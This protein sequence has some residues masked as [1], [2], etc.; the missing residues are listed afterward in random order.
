VSADRER[1][2]RLDPETGRP[3]GRQPLVGAGV[4]DIDARD[5]T[6]W[7]ANRR[8][9][10]VVRLDAS[11]GARLGTL[12]FELPPIAVAADGGG[13][14]VWV[15]TSTAAEGADRLLHVAAD[16]T[17][18]ARRSV[19]GGVW[20]LAWADGSLWVAHVVFRISRFDASGRPARSEWL[21]G[22]GLAFAWG[23]GRMYA[24]AEET[25]VVRIAPRTLQE[26]HRGVA[27]GPRQLT[28][29]GGRI[30]VADDVA[31]QVV[32]VGPRTLKPVT[33]LDVPPNPYAI[34]AGGGHVWVTGTGRNTVTRIDY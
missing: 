15:A 19:P 28:V 4:V 1:L 12:S 18:R 33:R 3:R 26:E 24:T 8:E 29:A 14:G 25:N 34:T 16:G 17:R 9:R 13:D 30:F 32:V 7:A 20:T 31:S 10:D 21:P 27:E 23:E 22:K 11:T 2:A 5:G 6:I